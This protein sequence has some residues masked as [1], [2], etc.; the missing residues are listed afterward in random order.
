MSKFT[1]I[2]LADKYRVLLTEVLPYELP[3][4][5]D[6]GCFYRLC[7]NG[8]FEQQHKK[9]KLF[10]DKA[11]IPLNYTISRGTASSP[12]V[13]SIMHP[14]SQ[15]EVCD[16][17]EKYHNLIKY[18]AT[19]SKHSLRYPY[20][21]ARKFYDKDE[22]SSKADIR[23]DVDGHESK[24]ASSY[25]KYKSIAFLYN[26]FESYQYHQLE[27]QFSYMLQVDIAKCFPSIYTHTLGWA[28]KSKRV[29]KNNLNGKGSFDRSFDD[30]MQHTNYRETNGIIVG[31]EV[32]R[33][34]SEIILQRIDLN[35]VQAME[36]ENYK[37]GKDFQFKRYV[38]DYFIF[39][40]SDNVKE[41]I[42]KKLEV[43]LVEYKLYLNEA[44]T[45]VLKRP[46][47][48]E[49]SL[50]KHSIN[51]ELTNF[52]ADRYKENNAEKDGQE[53]KIKHA[54]SSCSN[55]GR[56]ANQAI[57]KI[58]YGFF[59][60]KVNY[61]SLSNYLLNIIEK[62]IT[63]FFKV[64]AK[65]QHESEPGFATKK[66]EEK[67]TNWILVD[68]DILFFIHA[69]D[70]RIRPTDRLA[71]CIVKI[72][73]NISCLNFSM[74]NLIHQK[75]FDGI[76]L[77]IDITINQSDVNGVETLNLLT[78]L[79]LLPDAYALEEGTLGKYMNKIT[80]GGTENVY[81]VFVTTM[82]FVRDSEKF[83][84]VREKIIDY[85][86]SFLKNHP[87]GPC[88]TEFFLLFFEFLSCPYI[89]YDIKEEV[90]IKVRKKYDKEI[91]NQ[92]KLS[93]GLNYYSKENAGLFVD[94]NNENFLRNNLEKK[95]FTFAYA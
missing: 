33:I 83:K 49:I 76:R 64:I 62:N 75:I 52:Y 92:N 44:K 57:A 58:K 60:Y 6:P 25:F 88:S 42:I 11:F 87:D 13:L 35:L 54:I 30:L 28:T 65:H 59:D 1:E 36:D 23:L 41:S 21:L 85:A 78:I 22:S 95:K 4:W 9:L 24:T 51:K 91:R 79:C 14:M 70:L 18:Y 3:I 46:F 20:R 84:K 56:I 31:P 90:Y 82:L 74:Q 55:P 43:C 45:D 5:F 16:F 10:K 81:F 26:F 66:L 47:A 40:N 77:A 86:L 93:S 2:D 29:I 73:D 48:T 94:W 15:L 50:A 12:R 80:K 69:M 53:D 7:S 17:Y 38:D 89:E 19:R 63:R 68:L 27:K 8:T 61:H 72:L 32:S 67:I 34:F 39:F 71:R 37:V